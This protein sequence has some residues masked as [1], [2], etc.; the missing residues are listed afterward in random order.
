MGIMNLDE[1][2]VKQLAEKFLGG[3]ASN[4]EKRILHEWYDTVNAGDTEIVLTDTAQTAEVF[5]LQILAEL[6]QMIAE[7]KVVSRQPS[8]IR[9]FR[10][11]WV[12]AASIILLLGTSAYLWLSRT[13]S[14]DLVKKENSNHLKQDIAPGGNKAI[15]TLND[16]STIVL[17]SAA[18]GTLAQQGNAKVL[19]TNNGQ[20][21]YNIINEKSTEVLY[22]TLATPR[23]G[24]YQL[25][26]P[27]GSKVWL[28]ATS[29]IRYPTAFIGNER[30]VEITG[31]AY[32]EVSKDASKKFLVTAN[33]ATT[34]VLGTHFNVN[35]YNDESAMK[36]TL[37][38]GSVKV[39]NDI[40][41]AILSPGQQAKI[42]QDKKVEVNKN[43]DEDEVMAWKNG[44]FQFNSLQVEDI[45]R[46]ISRWYDVEVAY[47]TKSNQKHFSGIVSRNSN[48][49][50]VLK[51]M[52]Q[53]GIKFK[54]EGKKITVVK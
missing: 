35:A 33:G 10:L 17:D 8:V 37:L 13:P 3:T 36:I 28:N 25:L 15:L 4:E 26:L 39:T 7:D 42:N 34:E 18:N 46:Q 49:S 23:G 31:E 30:K 24:Q 43:I 47:E 29:S 38:E 32:F 54:I 48:V 22:N 19:K 2:Q 50:E 52:E 5:G 12:A 6:K 27:D 21:A 45:M 11:R 1:N 14:S 41:Y 51:I 53:A 40:F 16:G 44:W 9:K 20:L